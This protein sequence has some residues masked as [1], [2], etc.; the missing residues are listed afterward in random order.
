MTNKQA[1]KEA[2]KRFGKH[3]C[4]EPTT[5]FFYAPKAKRTPESQ[6][7]ARAHTQPCPSGL[8]MFKVGKIVMGM[9]FEVVADGS[10]WEAAFA[11]ADELKEKQRAKYEAIRNAKPERKV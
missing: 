8:P 7:C 1:L 4:V 6:C 11:H 2:V 5:C 3:A 10:T 9:F